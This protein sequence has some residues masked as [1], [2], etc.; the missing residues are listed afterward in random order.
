MTSVC[1]VAVYTIGMLMLVSRW[2]GMIGS[3][4]RLWYLMI[5]YAQETVE[6]N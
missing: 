6:H 5:R 3:V 1:V 4:I 2:H